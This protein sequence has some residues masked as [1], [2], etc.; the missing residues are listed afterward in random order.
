MKIGGFSIQ[1]KSKSGFNVYC[2]MKNSYK[3]TTAIFKIL[4]I[5]LFTGTI[6]TFLGSCKTC[7]CP[8]Y[9]HIEFQ[10][11]LNTGDSNV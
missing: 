6:S 10:K 4:V 7:K 5:V 2:S 3:S 1:N 9:S 11:P 8:A